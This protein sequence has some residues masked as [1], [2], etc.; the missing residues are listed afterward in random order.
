MS[1]RSRFFG[2]VILGMGMSAQSFS[3][4]ACS[5]K[6]RQESSMARCVTPR[7]Q[8]FPMLR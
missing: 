1:R 5:H 6:L 2:V 8:L 4:F 3:R 7:A